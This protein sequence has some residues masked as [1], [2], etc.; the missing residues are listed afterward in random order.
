MADR[1]GLRSSSHVAALG[2]RP[3]RML[4]TPTRLASEDDWADIW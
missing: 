1:N 2:D 3:A 4:S